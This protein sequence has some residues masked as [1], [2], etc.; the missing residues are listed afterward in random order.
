MIRVLDTSELG[1]LDAV[2]T[3]RRIRNRELGAPE[4]IAAA[5][6]RARA[7]NP[8]LN[9]IFT[10]TY[11][12][13]RTG[14]DSTQPG[15]FAGIPTFIKGLDDVAGVINDQGSRAFH[16]RVARKTEPYVGRLLATGLIS[17]GQSAAPE[18]GLNAATEPLAYGPTRNPWNTDHSTGGSS[19]GAAALVASGVVPLA[20]SSDA[21]GS[22]R[23][24]ASSCG[25]VGL[26]PSRGRRFTA[27]KAALLPVQ[28]VTYGAVTRSVRDSAH[29]IAALE[30]ASP[31]PK[32]YRNQA[33]CPPIGLVEGPA[34]PRLRIGVYTDSPLGNRVDP[35][36]REATLAAARLCSALGHD[37]EEIG[38]PYEGGLLDDFWIYI[39]LVA[40]ATIQQTRLMQPLRFDPS[41][42]EPWTRGLAAHGRAGW[43]STRRIIRQ[44]N[45]THDV[46]ARLF[47][48]GAGGF[49]ALLCPTLAAPPP[50]IGVL[51]PDKP[52]EEL[53][54][55]EKHHICFTPIQNAS[56][57]PA[58]S[59]PMGETRSGLPIGVQF[60]APSGGEAQLLG[61]AYELEA[62]GS[63]RTLSPAGVD[64]DPG[65][66]GQP[67]AQ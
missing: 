21:G 27:A 36:V 63:F 42:F 47:R 23:I 40:Y 59:L 37:V 20:H 39:G 30:A 34:E 65:A 9:A 56:G 48:S 46:S 25:L 3:A 44:L 15:P 62:T 28:I 52:F 41:N 17:L 13:A 18:I 29:F 54:P 45:A 50:E 5:I 8:R 4:V 51:A 43:R 57:E 32:P 66:T 19:G 61:L 7:L 60:A 33:T 24:P 12:S 53:L 10:E 55:R 14:A 38:C 67:S 2:E 58:I 16:G 6:E 22:I 64:P 11:E 49:D 35:E 31:T 26:K 1:R